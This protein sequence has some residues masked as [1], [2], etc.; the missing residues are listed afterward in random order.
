MF[1]NGSITDFKGYQSINE[2]MRK[3]V[4]ALGEFNSIQY[5]GWAFEGP[6]KSWE[7]AE[8]YALEKC[9]SK[10]PKDAPPC[11]VYAH[12]NDIIYLSMH[13]RLEKAKKLFES[14]DLAATEN[15]LNDIKQRNLSAL[16]QIEKGE[17]E[18]L[19]GKVLIKSKNEQDRSEAIVHFNNSWYK[20]CN[21]NGAV[22][23][24]NLLVA[25]GHIDKNWKSIRYPYQYFLEHASDEQKS[26]HPEVEQNLK[27]IEPYYQAD[28]APQLAAKAKQERLE[29]LKEKHEAE[30]QAKEERLD[31]KRIAKEGDGS[32]DDLICKK[33]GA[34]PGT[35]VYVDCRIK[36]GLAKTDEENRRREEQEENNRRVIAARRAEK[37]QHDAEQAQR[38]AD[39]NARN[40]NALIG[41]GLGIAN[42]VTPQ[43][44]PV[45]YQN[46]QVCAY[47]Q[48]GNRG[49]CFSDIQSCM[50]FVRS[51]QGGQCH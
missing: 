29:A 33:Y 46:P 4:F 16:S 22:E 12:N 44:A 8:K 11:E 48:Y 40:G 43:P 21:V 38:D 3:K 6:L 24:G 31:A 47:D 45:Q 13:A 5:C 18:Y 39:Q 26:R 23:E 50:L 49:S 34:K 28:I 42:G 14:G 9:E 19:F 10:R 17:Y 7:L 27:L 1:L 51:G 20:H 41:I 32:E 37:A 2:F 35:R 25:E 36:L 30:Q 15:A